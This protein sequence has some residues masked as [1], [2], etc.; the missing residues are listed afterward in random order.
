MTRLELS[1]IGS[2][3]GTI[4]LLVM[5]WL[6]DQFG[7]TESLP[8]KFDPLTMIPV[9]VVAIMTVI[10]LVLTFMVMSRRSFRAVAGD[11]KYQEVYGDII[12][13]RAPAE[14]SKEQ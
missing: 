2:A 13:Y 4:F 14:R 9:F 6:F 10:T 1:L 12:N 7:S 5:L 8:S 11:E 3:G